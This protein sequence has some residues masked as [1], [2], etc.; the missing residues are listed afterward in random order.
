MNRKTLGNT[1]EDKAV[2]YLEKK[3]YKI[4][5]RNYKYTR[6]EV[7]IIA[8]FQDFIVFVEVKMRRSLKYG[9]PHFAV[10]FRKQ[11]KIRKTALHYLGYRN[12]L[13]DRRIRF[14]VICIQM[15]GD[16][17]ELEHIENAF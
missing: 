2:E 16:R 8:L 15:K 7:D 10:D 17:V 9:P 14:D 11:E 13:C 5:E 6:G 12:G 4:I 3:G 1:G